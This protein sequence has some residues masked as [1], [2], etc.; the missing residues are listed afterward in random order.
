MIEFT[1][2]LRAEDAKSIGVAKEAASTFSYTV[3]TLSVR[4][5]VNW[6][7]TVTVT[8]LTTVVAKPLAEVEIS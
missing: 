1:C 3:P 7:P 5:T 8:S 2:L 4:F 6:S